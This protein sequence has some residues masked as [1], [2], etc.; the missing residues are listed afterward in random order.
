[1][2]NVSRRV[3][4]LLSL[5]AVAVTSACATVKR[6]EF[7]T[8]MTDLRSEM[9]AGDQHLQSEIDATNQRQQAMEGRL[10]SF[11]QE[12]RTLGDEFQATVER[13]EAAI[14]FNTPIYFAFD[15]DQLQSQYRPLLDQFAS[16][17]QSYYPGAHVTV[18][19]FTDPSG[20]REY[21]MRLGQ[22]RAET[23]KSYLESQG[24]PSG[25]LKAVSYGPDTNRLV[26]P[27]ER[28]PGEAGWQ[29]RRVVLVIDHADIAG[30]SRTVTDAYQ[31]EGPVGS[32]E[33]S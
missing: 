22:R 15:D 13:L 32:D 10:N 24:L 20:P 21:N 23:V 5:M 30:V 7:Q 28:G 27:G 4:M 3:L 29:N 18:E 31:G 26:R 33:D 25:Q 6:D 16:V 12:L 1:M 8:A 14:R 9:Q 17:V 11:Q 19:G 2:N